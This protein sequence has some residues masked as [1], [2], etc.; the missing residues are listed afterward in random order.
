M[1]DVNALGF[2]PETTYGDDTAPGKWVE[3]SDFTVDEKR[4][5]NQ[6]ELISSLGIKHSTPHI[7]EVTGSFNMLLFPE[8]H[9]Y[10][11]NTLL[12]TST[13]S[14]P[15]DS[16]YTHVNTPAG[17]TGSLTVSATHDSNTSNMMETFPGFKLTDIKYSLKAG[18]PVMCACNY[19]AKTSNIDARGSPSFGTDPPMVMM[20]SDDY[21]K[22]GGSSDSYITAAEI[23]LSRAYPSLDAETVLG[24]MTRGF[25]TPGIIKM[26][27]TMDRI[28][29]EDSALNEFL[30]SASAVAPAEDI[31]VHTLDV[32]S[33]SNTLVG[34]TSVYQVNWVAD[35]IILDTR[36]AK[37]GGQDLEVENIGWY[38]EDDGTS[39]FISINVKN[40]RTTHT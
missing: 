30:G 20:T 32:R 28:F 31:N 1:S 8:Y 35:R 12:G 7:Y 40:S 37:Q 34:A 11:L 38:A 19:L 18:E 17:A 29:R 5:H 39:D 15:A 27:G 25:A 3:V 24:S 13:P 36:N 22:Y 10:F 4:N 6:P 26:E 33:K 23:T 21:F 9:T 14:G 2:S 16:L